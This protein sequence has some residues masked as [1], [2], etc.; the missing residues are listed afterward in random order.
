MQLTSVLRAL[1]GGAVPLDLAGPRPSARG[2][3]GPVGARPSRPSPDQVRERASGLP[4]AAAAD[5]VARVDGLSDREAWQ[6]VEPLR[7]AP[8]ASVL[9]F[10]TAAARQVDE[11]ACGAAVLAMIAAHADPAVALWLVTGEALGPPPPVLDGV[12]PAAGP[13]GR[14]AGLQAALHVR[15]TRRALLGVLPWPTALGT[16]PWG[17]AR[18]ASQIGAR[19]GGQRSTSYRSVMLD[20]T[21]PDEI[22]G[23]LARAR[24]ALAEGIPV[25]LYTGGDT[26][27]G[28]AAAAPRHVVLLTGLDTTGLDTTGADT[29]GTDTAGDDTAGDDTAETPGLRV[30]EP[31]SGREHVLAEDAL[32]DGGTPRAAYGGWSHACWALL[33]AQR[34]ARKHEA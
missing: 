26:S 7:P 6:V 4:P 33:P 1:R 17:A 14:L 3:V 30:Y 8:G 29:A 11:T 21:R 28:W 19:A 23:M 20:D 15:S 5:L 27:D 10:G 24:R 32:L 9:R 13:A 22:G 31:S 25:P 2:A 16:P 18:V 34:P 12:G